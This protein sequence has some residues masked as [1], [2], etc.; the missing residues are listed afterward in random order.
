[1]STTLYA[2]AFPKDSETTQDRL[3]NQVV[4]LGLENR[5]LKIEL[6]LTQQDAKNLL[7]DNNQ[8]RAIEMSQCGTI[9]RLKKELE[10]ARKDWAHQNEMADAA[11]HV[12][13]EMGTTHEDLDRCGCEGCERVRKGMVEAGFLEPKETEDA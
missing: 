2:A 6:E 7:E 11:A 12:T 3:A 1:M 8:R 13:I 4:E 10:Q 9:A 5:R